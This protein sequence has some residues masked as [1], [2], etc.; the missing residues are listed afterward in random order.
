MKN[1]AIFTGQMPVNVPDL[2][3]MI[4]QSS[5]RLGRITAS[6]LHKVA[7][8]RQKDAWS[9]TAMTYLFDLVF[10][11]VT[12]KP[13]NDFEGNE[14]TDWGN[15]NEAK[16]IAEYEV[17]ERKFVSPG[18]FCAAKGFGMFGAT[19][20]G[21]IG[22][23]GLLEVKCPFSP[24]N[25]FR[26]VIRDRIPS[27]YQSQVAGQLLATGRQWADFVSYDPRID[28]PALRLHV[29]HVTRND[30]DLDELA[31]RIGKFETM[32]LETL[33]KLSKNPR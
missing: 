28:D 3:A 32:L 24:K 11:N 20:D 6:N 18:K 31:E 25:H 13:A 1:P 12:G 22:T 15:E 19:P 2:G 7:Y 16:A 26:T 4:P 27:E 14:A 23:E 9:E 8:T 17:R 29:V 5:P 33:A 10:E 30:F 21:F